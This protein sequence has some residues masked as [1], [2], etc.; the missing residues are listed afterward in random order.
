MA[1]GIMAISVLYFGTSQAAHQGFIPLGVTVTPLWR[2]VRK[3][4]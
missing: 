3:I 2:D 4:E 1:S